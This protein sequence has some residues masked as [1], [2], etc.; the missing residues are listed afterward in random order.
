[1]PAIKMDSYGGMLPAWD[2][3]LLP[4]G[5]ASY[6]RNC[7]LFSGTLIGW[8]QPKLLHQLQSS[9]AKFVYRIPD[10]QS[11]DT[12]IL[13]PDSHWMEF[14]DPDTTVVHSPVVDD[15]YNRYYFASPSQVPRYNTYPR[16]VNGDH[17]W[18]L[19]V[20]ASGCA[21][22]V[23]VDG[24]GDTSELGYPQILPGGGGQDFRPG[25]SIF[26]VPITPTGS[27]LIQDVKFVPA[28]TNGSL[29]YQAVVY[30]DS[31]GVPYQLLGEGSANIGVAAGAPATATID[32]GVSVIANATYWIGIAIDSDCYIGIANVDSR[33]GAAISNTFTN[34]PPN[35]AS[36][37]GGLPNWNMWADLAG[38]S[39]YEARSYVYTWVTEYDEE[40]PPSLPPDPIIYGWSN[41][42]WTISLFTPLPSDMGV[43]R[44]ITKTRIYRTVSNQSGQGTYY[45]VAEIPVTQ[46][47][48]VD[49]SRDSDIAL[50]AQLVSLYWHEPPSDLQG[51]KSFPNGITV[52]FRDNEVWFSEAY[53]PHAWPP[54]Y[55]ITTEFPIVG[56][57]VCGTSIV[58]CTQGTPYVIT[59][60]NPAA[61]SLTKINLTE[62]CLHRGSIV[63]TDT[64]VLYV[65]QN[66][67]MQISQSGAGSNITEAWVSRDKWQEL[68]PCQQPGRIRAIKHA[69]SYFAFG[70]TT[71]TDNSVAQQGFTIDLSPM[72]Q[73]SFTVWPQAGGHRLGFNELTAP[74]GFDIDNVELDPW[75]GVGLLVQGGG[76]YYYDFSDANPII[77]PYL[78]RSKVYKQ[79]SRNSYAAMRIWFDVPE[80]TPPQVDRNVNDP[81]PVLGPNQYGIVR[82]YAD[83]N[84][85]TTREIRTDGEVLRIYSGIKVEEW[86]FELES[87]VHITN[88]Q[89]AT[90][91]KALGLV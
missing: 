89:I 91:V 10:M 30:S 80:T 68:T 43:D 59:G 49:T 44:N 25:N 46:G 87:R 17:S 56:I 9:T 63:A 12:R 4:E 11:N 53:R 36:P 14:D 74:N 90:S 41:A 19:G 1:M 84:L 40:G 23:V 29:R 3:R 64:T 83:G 81:Q 66:G 24:G 34:G 82:V 8:R 62:P 86:Q 71:P 76:V 73:T 39:V 65:S 77:V 33:T 20:P 28:T 54:S 26:L 58:V 37:S 51:I 69:T 50:N 70:T 35:F 21:P 57:G 27:L 88:M 78:W 7:Y 85:W 38:A 13:A 48:Y 60:V 22:G 2:D 79:K 5:Q 16:I 45:F 67:L 15:Q 47:V 31:G 61:M 18:L 6:S 42:T 32:N 75:T 52:G 55:T 72:E